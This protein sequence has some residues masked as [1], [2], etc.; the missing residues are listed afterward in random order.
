M[1]SRIMRAIIMSK[2]EADRLIEWHRA[3]P[4]AEPAMKNALTISIKTHAALVKGRKCMHA[5]TDPISGDLGPI[6]GKG[7][8]KDAPHGW[9]CWRH[10]AAAYGIKVPPP[11]Q[12]ATVPLIRKEVAL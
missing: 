8:E 1:T 4:S 11:S 12:V 9:L 5:D 10:Y 6:C 3:H 7:V 2:V